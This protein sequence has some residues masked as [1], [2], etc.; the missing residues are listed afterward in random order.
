MVHRT[1]ANRN[2]PTSHCTGFLEIANRD[3]E[4]RSRTGAIPVPCDYG[5]SDKCRCPCTP[6]STQAPALAVTQHVYIPLATPA[7][8]PASDI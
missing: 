2:E 4:P 7:I 6:T 3:P 1:E 5:T 8:A